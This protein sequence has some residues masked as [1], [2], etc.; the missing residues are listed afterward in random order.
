[1]DALFTRRSIRRYRP[2]PVSREVLAEIMD[3]TLSAPSGNNL[4][5]WYYVVIHSPKAMAELRATLSGIGDAL[6]PELTERFANH[7]EVVAETRNFVDTLGGAPV[8]VLVF[9]LR[10]YAD[11]RDTAV[12][13][14]AMSIQNLMLAA[15]AHGLG[16]CCLTAPLYTGRSEQLRARFAPGKGEFLA[17]VTLGHP[18]QTAKMP[19]RRAGRCDFI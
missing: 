3:G 19:P 10:D 15:H 7:P 9:L 12:M 16:T 2:A 17:L 5:P 14:A 13:S 8:C 18:D 6:I 11:Q 1:M 4:Q